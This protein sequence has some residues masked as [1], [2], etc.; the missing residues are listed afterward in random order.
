M[1]SLNVKIVTLLLWTNT[2][3]FSNR[4]QTVRP[5][6][7]ET[8]A[9]IAVGTSGVFFHTRMS[10]LEGKL[11]GLTHPEGHSSA[12]SSEQAV[13]PSHWPHLR[14]LW[15]PTDWLPAAQG[16]ELCCPEAQ[17]FSLQPGQR[18]RP[19]GCER[20]EINNQCAFFTPSITN[21][22]IQLR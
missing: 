13:R 18:T 7:R 1:Y 9:Q 11:V 3:W 6:R 2:I 14:W 20:A 21:P 17:P 19:E 5:K 22:V 12:A 15:V 8:E 10:F 16:Q 4:W